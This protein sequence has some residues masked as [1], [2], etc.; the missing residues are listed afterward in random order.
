[1]FIKEICYKI[2]QIRRRI[3]SEFFT[4]L[5]PNEEGVMGEREFP[6]R[7]GLWGNVV[8]PGLWGNVSS[9]KGGGYGGT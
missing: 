3:I 1:M 6:Q 5:S 4:F 7:R 9:P 2:L 8:L